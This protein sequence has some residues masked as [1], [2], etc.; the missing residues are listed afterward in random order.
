M[1][2][3]PST[4]RFPA[5]RSTFTDPEYE[6]FVEVRDCGGLVYDARIPAPGGLPWGSQGK[7]LGLLSS[8]IDSPV[9]SWLAMKRGCEVS[10]LHMDGGRWAGG[11]VRETAIENHRRLSLWCPGA[12]LQMI[13]ADTEPFYDRMQELRIPARPRCVLCKRFMLRPP[14]ASAGARVP[15]DPHRGKSRA[16]GL[17]DP[18]KP[19]SDFRCHSCPGAAASYHV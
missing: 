14:A 4:M 17:P 10:H 19:C 3:L 1:L 11:D 18:C 6:L 2:D 12:D 5:S 16:G 7:A 8:G 13:I 9:A 15:G